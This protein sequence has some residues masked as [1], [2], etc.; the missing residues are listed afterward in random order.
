MSLAP[1]PFQHFSW[2]FEACRLYPVALRLPLQ[3]RVCL[4]QRPPPPQPTPA[5]QGTNLRQTL[6]VLALEKGFSY[7]WINTSVSLSISDNGQ[8]LLWL[9][10]M[11]D[12]AAETSAHPVHHPCFHALA[13]EQRLQRGS[14]RLRGGGQAHAEVG[15]RQAC[16]E[17]ST[18]MNNKVQELFHMLLNHEKPATCLQP[19]QKKSQML[20]TTDQLL[21]ITHSSNKMLIGKDDPNEWLRRSQSLCKE[22]VYP[23]IAV[24]AP[25][26]HMECCFFSPPN[27]ST[28][29]VQL[30][31]NSLLEF[32]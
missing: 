6:S 20:K 30:T 22:S 31:A 18:K 17:T 1:V 26:S 23:D 8:F 27:P 28:S 13:K 11:A 7:C 21:G 9:Q 24:K 16:V 32:S 5:P 10:G 14:A 15:A 2:I 19:P 29:L 3:V 25:A 12:P 4:P